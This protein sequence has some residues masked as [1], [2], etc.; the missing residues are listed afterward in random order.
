MKAARLASPAGFALVLMLFLFLPFLSVSCDVGLGTIGADYTGAG[1]AT[2]ARPEVEVPQGLEGITEELPGSPDDPAPDPG[3]QVL[4][5]IL[6]VV[7]VAGVVLP[8][9]P[10]LAH[11]VRL[12]MFGGAALAVVA[13]IVAI[14]TQVVAQSNLT[15]R[16][17]DYA[18]G[19][20]TD[21]QPPPSAD[22]V[23]QLVHSGVG[24]W[25]A[26][27]LLVVLVLASVGFVYR[28]RIFP[29]SGP[30]STGRSPGPSTGPI[31]R[32]RQDRTESD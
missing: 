4:A 31:W 8:F 16:L 24:F 1:L 17:T 13:G 27:V 10:R 25:L 30:P 5:I 19:L 28:D 15:A 18:R 26:M 11:Q 12:R 20:A 2:D 14:V 22:D 23:A 29:G 6:A 21:E 32:S 3:V 9:L 7:L